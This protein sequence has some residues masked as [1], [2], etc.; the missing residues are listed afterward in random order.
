MPKDVMFKQ[1]VF[2][3]PITVNLKENSLSGIDS[4]PLGNAE[5]VKELIGEEDVYEFVNKVM[6][7][8]DHPAKPDPYTTIVLTKEWAESF[9]SALKTPKPLFIG[10]HAEFGVSYKERPIPDGYLVGGIVKNDTLYLR[11]ALP[12]GSTET[13]KERTKQ[14]VREIKAKML[15]TSTSDYMK[16]KISID[17]QG[18]ETYFAVESVKGQSNALVEADQTGSEAEIILTSFKTDDSLENKQKGEKSMDGKTN[19]ELFVSMKNQLDSGRLALS[20]VA[21][22]LGIE[23]MTSN[24][25][26]ALKRLNDAESKVG[27]V[28]EFVAKVTA[29]RETAFNALKEAKIK[30]KFKTEELIEI[31][32][33][34]FAL[35]EGDASAIEAEV[36]RL[37]ELKVFKTIQ[38][39]A[40]SAGNVAPGSNIE[41]TLE[42]SSEVMEG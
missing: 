32:T 20:E 33:P 18:H 28:T 37:A 27:N 23:I 26:T 35:K 1:M 40:L 14:T 39:T 31:A 15:S 10:G 21:S 17:D 24:Q 38:G 42:E 5:L 34:L 16:Y 30:D 22:G 8:E 12:A 6:L 29:E 19:A 13:R 2:R 36:D 7:G 41:D 25:K 9:I 3:T 11:N 4:V